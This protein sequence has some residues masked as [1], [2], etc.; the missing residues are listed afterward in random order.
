MYTLILILICININDEDNVKIE[1][2]SISHNLYYSY[3]DNIF[4]N[5]VGFCYALILNFFILQIFNTLII[6]E[7]TL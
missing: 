1:V 3:F 4:V 7:H 2:I 6:V 5:N